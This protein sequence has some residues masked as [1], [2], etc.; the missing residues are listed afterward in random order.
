MIPGDVL[1]AIIDIEAVGAIAILCVNLS[2]K[3]HSFASGQGPFSCASFTDALSANSFSFLKIFMLRLFAMHLPSAIA[4][5]AHSARLL[6]I[7][8]AICSGLV[9]SGQVNL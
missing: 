9:Y 4:A 6:L 7:E 8:L 3:L 1:P 2:C 5:I